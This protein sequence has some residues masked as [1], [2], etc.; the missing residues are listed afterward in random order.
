MSYGRTAGI[1]LQCKPEEQYDAGL[2]YSPCTGSTNGVGPVC[3]G[4]CPAGTSSCGGALCL[5]P[6]QDCSEWIIND[7][8]NIGMSITS[9]AEENYAGAAIDITNVALDYTFLIC[10]TYGVNQSWYY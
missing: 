3:W 6:D 7:V 5:T 8:K 4:S 2:C 9:L 1:P 10:Q